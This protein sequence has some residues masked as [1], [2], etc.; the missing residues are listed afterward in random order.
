M[1][2]DYEKLFRTAQNEEHKIYL[3]YK[4]AVTIHGTY[5]VSSLL[6]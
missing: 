5:N 4:E 6:A 2:I 1:N 3:K